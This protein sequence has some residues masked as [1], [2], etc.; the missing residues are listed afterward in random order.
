[1]S[2][3]T[4]STTDYSVVDHDSDD[5]DDDDEDAVSITQVTV[6]AANR[7]SPLAKLVES[8]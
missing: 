1:M 3:P 7:R 4:K 5:D 2:A 6:G 8:Q